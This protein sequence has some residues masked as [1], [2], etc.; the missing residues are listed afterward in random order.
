MTVTRAQPQPMRTRPPADVTVV[1]PCYNQAHFLGECLRSIRAQ[2]RETWRAIVVDD[3]SPDGEA[4]RVVVAQLEDDRITLERHG[5]NRGLAAARN[6]GIRASRTPYVL[7]VDADDA[8][9][10]HYLERVVSLMDADPALDIAFSDMGLFGVMEGVKPHWVPAPGEILRGQPVP[11]NVLMTRALWERV[12]GYDESATLR[13][14]R[15]DW[16]FFIRAFSGGCRAAHVPEPLYRYRTALQSMNIACRAQEHVVRRYIYDKHRAL[17]DG[18]GQGRAVLA[19]GY[20]RAAA[21]AG[22]AG[23][24]FRMLRLATHALVLQPSWR[25]ARQAAR[26]MRLLSG[27]PGPRMLRERFASAPRVS[28]DP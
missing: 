17:F 4:I 9:D 20:D 1:V 18:A 16:E 21:A 3:A 13:L 27:L 15:E 24:G 2:T 7:P 22:A 25:R 10:P 5:V 11:P 23:D 8:L 26:A 28:T 6:T 19:S 12:G 14:G